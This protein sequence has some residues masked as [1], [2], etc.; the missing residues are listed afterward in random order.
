MLRQHMGTVYKEIERNDYNAIYVQSDMKTG[1]QQRV[2]TIS[3]LDVII[4]DEDTKEVY[5]TVEQYW[6][7]DDDRGITLDDKGDRKL[8]N[9][10]NEAIMYVAKNK[11]SLIEFVLA[12][13]KS[14]GFKSLTEKEQEL[15][16]E[17]N[18]KNKVKTIKNN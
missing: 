4:E 11:S 6:I 1:V 17:H 8:F 13:M 10:D 14:T 2:G 3:K 12:K 5:F 15:L 7:K 16:K 18:K 9:T